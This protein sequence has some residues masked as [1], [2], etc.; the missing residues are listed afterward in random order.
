MCIWG[1]S[2]HLAPA[3]LGLP[4]GYVARVL[5]APQTSARIIS[6][7]LW[8]AGQAQTSPQSPCPQA[9]SARPLVIF[10]G[11]ENHVAGK[12]VYQQPSLPS[13]STAES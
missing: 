11:R 13:A 7:D 9:W 1:S 5:P 2:S 6:P 3:H 8:N 12:V 4:L 10:L